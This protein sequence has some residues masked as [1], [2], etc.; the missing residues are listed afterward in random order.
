M[1]ITKTRPA[2]RPAAFFSPP[3]RRAAGLGPRFCLIRLT[4][5]AFDCYYCPVILVSWLERSFGFLPALRTP[6]T[7]P[8][9]LNNRSVVGSSRLTYRS[10]GRH[11]FD[12]FIPDVT[13]V[14][15]AHDA[16]CARMKAQATPP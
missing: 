3:R 1:R 5:P 15:L 14:E 16:Y 6:R 12:S 10:Q 11:A 4:K 2:L 7:V 9:A 13:P 8:V